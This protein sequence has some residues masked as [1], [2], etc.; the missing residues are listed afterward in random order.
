MITRRLFSK[1]AL[2]VLAFMSSSWEFGTAHARV[3]GHTAVRRHNCSFLA[4][5]RR[6]MAFAI[7]QGKLAPSAEQTVQCPLCLEQLKI[8][9]A[10]AFN[11]IRFDAETLT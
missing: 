8:T 5:A 3:L 6:E 1:G 10:D 2:A 11:Q 9:A 4:S 7:K